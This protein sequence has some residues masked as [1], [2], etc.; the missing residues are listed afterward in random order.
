MK[1]LLVLIALA[2]RLALHRRPGGGGT[3]TV[4]GG[5][6]PSQQHGTV[7]ASA[8]VS[9]AQNTTGE[10][11][12]RGRPAE[13][14]GGTN[15]D[16]GDGTGRPEGEGEDSG[17]GSSRPEWLDNLQE[18]NEFNRRREPYYED[19]GGANEVH[20]EPR[21]EHNQYR[22]VDSYVPGEEIVSR[23]YTQLSEIQEGTAVGYLREFVN[24]YNS[25]TV[26]ADTPT[27][28]RDL[29]DE[30][31]G[32]P[33]SGDLILEVPVQRGDPPVPRAILEEAERLNITIRDENGRI[34]E[35]P[36]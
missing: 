19:Q 17:T 20:V 13:S 25:G 24:H 23:K 5:R 10:F 14:G 6:R 22:R 21:T 18:G 12:Q 4:P 36:E 29:G 7:D 1:T 3:P 32:Q 28:R 9:S 31:I 34:Y 27:N 2:T 26:I 8:G 35:L 15:G 11:A 30:Q 16:G 33:M